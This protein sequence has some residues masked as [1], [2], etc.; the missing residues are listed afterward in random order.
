VVTVHGVQSRVKVPPQSCIAL[1]YQGDLSAFK[2]TAV[3]PLGDR[4]SVRMLLHKIELDGP[5]YPFDLTRTTSLADVTDMVASG[6]EEMWKQDLLWY[7]HD[8][9][10]IFHRKWGGLSFA[11]EVEDGDDP[12]NNFYPVAQRM[13][14]RYTGRAA[15][16]DY[17]CKH[18]DEVLFVRTGC[19]SRGEVEN[20]LNRL[21][22]RYPDLTSRMR[23]LMISDQPTEEF[24]GIQG[25]SHVRENFDPDRMYEEMQYWMHC[26]HQFRGILERHGVTPKNLYWCPNNLKEAEAEIAGARKAKGEKTADSPADSPKNVPAE[27]PQMPQR[28]ANFS[29]SNLYKLLPPPLKQGAVKQGAG[30][31]IGA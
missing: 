9:G 23:M 17:A 16:F 6:F 26:S 15:R 2:R 10:R 31:A 27:E 29:H 4:C 13:A 25:F 1:T 14:K 30:P 20:C 24:N 3:L 5:C 7:D 12:V 11:H 21:R 19:A 8:A 22:A 28:V 18:A